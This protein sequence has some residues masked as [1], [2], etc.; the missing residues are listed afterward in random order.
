MN[1][2][3]VVVT[4]VVVSVIPRDVAVTSSSTPCKLPEQ[5]LRMVHWYFLRAVSVAWPK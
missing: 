2:L 4:G 5:R 3:V 1:L